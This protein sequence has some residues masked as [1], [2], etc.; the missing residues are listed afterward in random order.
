MKQVQRDVVF[1]FKSVY[2]KANN[3]K[4]KRKNHKKKDRNTDWDMIRQFSIIPVVVLGWFPKWVGFRQMTN[5]V[6]I[7]KMWGNFTMN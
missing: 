2:K 6:L 4:D 3:I 1:D 7:D 5:D